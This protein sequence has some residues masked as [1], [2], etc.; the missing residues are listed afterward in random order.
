[1]SCVW[2]RR[3]GIIFGQEERLNE[4]FELVVKALRVTCSRSGT[5]NNIPFV[6]LLQV[7]S[8]GISG[9][10]IGQYKYGTGVL[11]CP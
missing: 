9:L 6:M 3:S 10:C 1:M 4:S 5:V 2:T 8:I 7:L 11:G